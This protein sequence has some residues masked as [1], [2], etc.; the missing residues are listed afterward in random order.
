MAAES[1]T[2]GEQHRR[3]AQTLGRLAGREEESEG[4]GSPRDPAPQRGRFGLA[5]V[6]GFTPQNI[7][8]PAGLGG[9]EHLSLLCVVFCRSRAYSFQ[10]IWKI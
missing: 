6:P 2:L 10:K 1:Q 5:G 8:F 7:Q 4:P 3:L 9:G